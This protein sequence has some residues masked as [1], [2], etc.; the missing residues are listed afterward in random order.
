MLPWPGC[1]CDHHATLQYDQLRSFMMNEQQSWLSRDCWGFSFEGKKLP[2]QMK[3]I[4]LRQEELCVTHHIAAYIWLP[5]ASGQKTMTW[6]S[7][8]GIL[9]FHVQCKELLL[10]F[11]SK[12]KTLDIH[13][14]SKRET[15]STSTSF[16]LK[17]STKIE[18][19]ERKKKKKNEWI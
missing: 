9:R 2:I 5:L 15:T 1:Q 11:I 17:I 16:A 13:R 19:E 14:F 8:S 6:W 3:H 4:F 12:H 7:R 18:K 10:N